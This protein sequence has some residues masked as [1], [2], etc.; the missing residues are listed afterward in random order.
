M[1]GVEPLVAWLGLAARCGR[2][3]RLVQGKLAD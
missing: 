2:R 3:L 1:E